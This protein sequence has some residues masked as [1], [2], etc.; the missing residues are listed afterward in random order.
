M[1]PAETAIQ[2]DPKYVVPYV[3]LSFL[4]V[5]GQRWKEVAAATETATK[6]D[7]FS[8]PQAFFLNAVANYNLKNMEVAGKAR[9]R[10]NRS[11][12]GINSE[13]YAP[14]RDHSGAAAGF[15]RCGRAL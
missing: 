8:Y 13:G 15:Y 10:R 9:A 11:T 14:S 5:Q 6:L 1:S 3:E 2:A 4:E 12:R 7:P